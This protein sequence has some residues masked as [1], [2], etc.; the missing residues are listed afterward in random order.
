MILA[1]WSI[2]GK[3]AHL[4]II[5]QQSTQNTANLLLQT[6]EKNQWTF[7][8]CST[9][10]STLVFA[11]TLLTQV[12]VQ[13]FLFLFISIIPWSS[14]INCYFETQ[15]ILYI[16]LAEHCSIGKFYIF[17]HLVRQSMSWLLQVKMFNNL[18]SKSSFKAIFYI[19]Q[20]G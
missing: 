5:P 2:L 3:S 7:F 20:T 8:C 1:S 13:K 12:L 18:M 10:A 9:R 4:Q 19:K 16:L 11:I 15:T 14:Q 6:Y 17:R